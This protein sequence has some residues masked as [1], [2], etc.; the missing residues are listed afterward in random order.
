MSNLA[1]DITTPNKLA[2][3]RSVGWWLAYGAV[4]LAVVTSAAFGVLSLFS[5]SAFLAIVGVPTGQL[6]EGAQVLAAYTGARE[7]AIA[8][9]LLALL[10]TKASRGLAAVMVLTGLANLFDFGHAIISQRWAQAPGALVFALIYLAAAAW[11]FNR[12]ARREIG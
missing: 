11:V 2:S 9:T 7:L 12:P 5:P 1:T 3:N 8:V 6:S 4:V 10:V